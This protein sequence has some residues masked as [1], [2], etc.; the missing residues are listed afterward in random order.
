M[1][2]KLNKNVKVEKFTNMLGIAIRLIVIDPLHRISTMG[3]SYVSNQRALHLYAIINK[4]SI[5]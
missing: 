5:L 2:E 4:N 1:N 3:N